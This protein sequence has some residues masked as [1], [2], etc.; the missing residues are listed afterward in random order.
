MVIMLNNKTTMKKALIIASSL[1][2]PVLLFAQVG[3]ISNIR[4]ALNA[5]ISIFNWLIWF[6]GAV[7]VFVI[8]WGAFQ[9]V[10]GAGDPEKRKEGRDKILWGIV[11]VVVMLTVWGLVNI[12][13]RTV[14]I[15]KNSPV[16]IKFLPI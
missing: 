7:A 16:P 1:L 10:V 5:A 13:Y 6:L 14:H 11:G 8:V 12:L 4:T 2:A 3:L 9:F 15:V